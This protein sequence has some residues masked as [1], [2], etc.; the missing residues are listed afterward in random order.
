[1]KCPSAYVFAFC[2]RQIVANCILFC[3]TFP[4]LASEPTPEWHPT[5][6]EV[7]V[8]FKNI[9]NAVL[10]PVEVDGKPFLFLLDTGST[11]T[12]ID[13]SLLKG[14]E[15]ATRP[16][17][18]SP[19]SNLKIVEQA[20]LTF[21]NGRVSTVDLYN[22]PDIAIRGLKLVS[23]LP[24]VSIDFSQSGSY[25]ELGVKI[26]GLI[27]MDR[28]RH[29]GL[30]L[31]YQ[32]NKVKLVKGIEDDSLPPGEC[33]RLYYKD[34]RPAAILQIGTYE[35][36]AVID[37]GCIDSML[38]LQAEVLE[39]VKEHCKLDPSK[40]SMANQQVIRNG[41]KNV[42]IDEALIWGKY[43]YQ[44]LK[45]ATSYGS[46]FLGASVL[47]RHCI[48]FDFEN[49]RLFVAKGDRY[50]CPCHLDFDGLQLG[51][52]EVMDGLEVV[53]VAKGSPSDKAG[54]RRG[55]VVVSILDRSA[56][57]LSSLEITKL[58]GFN[59]CRDLNVC[60]VRNGSILDIVLPHK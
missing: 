1:M 12:F 3:I 18:K 14:Y 26:H 50:D 59:R 54:I 6:L 22:S 2:L 4:C 47:A 34:I 46:N 30:H 15:K 31:D 43:S 23:E 25:K 29:H 27:G 21:Q 51:D 48:T 19:D 45:I 7:S 28:I 20:K 42:V 33:S 56:K 55:D 44:P 37:T 8:D 11:F 60:V 16:D 38:T 32:R 17:P 57:D 35:F 49:N 58:L 41:E 53:E 9:G 39:K 13:E 10:I 40:I 5:N 36:S 24:V 52:G